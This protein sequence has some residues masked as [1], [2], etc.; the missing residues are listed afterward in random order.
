MTGA[1]TGADLE[2]VRRFALHG[3]TF[4]RG[5][6]REGDWPG[7]AKIARRAVAAGRV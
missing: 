6:A 7:E 5:E 3:P 4:H 1:R 2:R